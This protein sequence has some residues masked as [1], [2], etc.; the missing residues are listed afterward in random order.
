[1]CWPCVSKQNQS[2][3]IQCWAPEYPIP[4]HI[5]Q[6]ESHCCKQQRVSQGAQVC[7]LLVLPTQCESASCRLGVHF[8]PVH[9]C[10][11]LSSYLTGCQLSWH[12]AQAC[13]MTP[14]TGVCLSSLDV[15]CDH[16]MIKTISLRTD[17]IGIP[18]SIR[19]IG[20][21]VKM[22]VRVP[23]CHTMWI[24]RCGLLYKGTSPPTTSRC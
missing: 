9:H 20:N 17:S 10:M 5:L 24:V 19:A 18:R 2:C 6:D 16:L 4:G 15:R 21:M 14:A 8:T 13:H 22:M 1:M 23:C 3:S 12:C 7:H 11:L